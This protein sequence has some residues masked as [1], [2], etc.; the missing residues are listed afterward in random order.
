MLMG[1]LS[2]PERIRERE[3]AKMLDVILLLARLY[4]KIERLKTKNDDLDFELSKARGAGLN[5]EGRCYMAL[6]EVERLKKKLN[7]MYVKAELER[8]EG[9]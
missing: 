9:D 5:W 8:R 7:V 6:E 1:L 4:R 2:D 3:E